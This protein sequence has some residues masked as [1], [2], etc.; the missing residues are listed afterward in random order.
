MRKYTFLLTVMLVAAVYMTATLMLGGCT[1]LEQAAEHLTTP[2][3][4]TIQLSLPQWP[5]YLPE[6]TGWKIELQQA[7]GI[8]TLSAEAD[9]PLTVKV[10]RNK[11]LCI[12]AQ[13][14]IAQPMVEQSPEPPVQ[15]TFFKCAGALYPY[16]YSPETEALELTWQG[17]YAATLMKAIINSGEQAGYS[18]EFT[19]QTVEQFNWERLVEIL[20]ENQ[21]QQDTICYNPWLLDRQQVL[22]GIAWQKFSATKLKLSGALAVELETPVFSSYI[23]ENEWLRAP[24]QASQY[25]VTVKKDGQALFALDDGTFTTGVLIYGT[26]LKNISLEFISLPIYIIE[27]L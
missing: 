22:E 23:P 11:P 24:E 17:G 3:Q 25:N 1:L 26:S 4:Q 27:G 7:N 9:R 12:I 2:E 15:S 13:P 20:N 16:M 5:D 19:R 8:R 6:L 14:I 18:K 21:A 10:P